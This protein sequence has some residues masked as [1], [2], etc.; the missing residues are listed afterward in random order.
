MN[1][2]TIGDFDN[3]D[4]GADND[5]DDDDW[6]Y[7]NKHWHSKQRHNDRMINHRGGGTNQD[8]QIRPHEKQLI[9]HWLLA[10]EVR[11]DK[12]DAG[13]AICCTGKDA[14]PN[15]TVEEGRFGR[16]TEFLQQLTSSKNANSKYT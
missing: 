10:I 3:K 6:W 14:F 9:F 12:V 1:V 13:E 8:V 2:M 7:Q 5:N 15:T 4:N 16:F 11:Q